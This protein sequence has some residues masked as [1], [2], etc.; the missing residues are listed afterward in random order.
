MLLRRAIRLGEESERRG[1][2]SCLEIPHFFVNQACA[3]ID[4]FP[5][6]IE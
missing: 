4:N 5:D 6:A 3:I 2:A 1:G